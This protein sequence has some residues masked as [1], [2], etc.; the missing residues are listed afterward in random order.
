MAARVGIAAQLG[1]GQL[2]GR[3]ALALYTILMVRELTRAGY[4]NFAYALAL[5][6][7]W[8]SLGDVGF[9]RLIIRDVSRTTE[10]GLLVRDMLLVRASAAFAATGIFAL[11]TAA[12]I[13]TFEGRFAAAITA[14]LLLETLAGGYEAAAVG[15][16][17]PF[18]FVAAQ[19][20]SA[21]VL[22]IA[23]LFVLRH[24]A[25]TPT[26]AMCGLASASFARTLV[27]WLIW[28]LGRSA[29]PANW[30]E[31]PALPWLRQALPFFGLA[32]LAA[33]YYRIGVVILHALKGPVETA[34]YAAA[35]RV[36]DAVAILGGIA[37]ATMSPVISRAHL[38]DPATLWTTWRRMILRTGSVAI[39][40]ALVVGYFG[41]EIA[42]VLFGSAYREETGR[43]LT[44]LAPGMALLILQN[45]T[46]T[47]VLMADDHVGVLR[48]TACNVVLATTL[49]LLLA[50]RY[51]SDGAAAATSAAEVISFG[52]FAILVRLRYRPTAHESATV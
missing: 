24:D 26:G 35:L 31:L 43:A 32:L 37:F 40:G 22:A 47:I 52:S 33:V 34:P 4:G 5:A 23:T 8:I 25:P 39:P 7:I 17:R 45:L 13:F 3:G 12:G 48:L 42:D 6:G 38:H 9:A 16:E 20:A 10:P 50:S 29:R 51:G 36:F 30:R 27:G 1:L 2:L 46:A 11:A 44:L 18:R 15:A 49:A 14:Y 28:R 19:A 21:L 41:T